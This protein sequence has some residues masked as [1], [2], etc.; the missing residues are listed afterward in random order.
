MFSGGNNSEFA[1]RRKTARLDIP[2]DVR[3]RVVSSGVEEKLALTKN[4][5]AGGC[6]LLSDENIESGTKI[7]LDIKLGEGSESLRICGTIVRKI[8]DGGRTSEYG[9]AFDEMSSEARRLFADFCFAKMYEMIGLSE[10]PTD[11]RKRSDDNEK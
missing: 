11:R 4:M 1:D 8:G 10:W 3:Y 5:S 2:L 6:L 9:I 7:E